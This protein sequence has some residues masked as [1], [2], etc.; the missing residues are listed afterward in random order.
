MC[1]VRSGRGDQM[2]VGRSGPRIVPGTCQLVDAVGD[3]RFS[4][5]DF[6]LSHASWRPPAGTRT[7]FPHLPHRIQQA[8]RGVPTVVRDQLHA[9]NTL[10]PESTRRSS[11]M[12][13]RQSRR[14]LIH[15]AGLVSAAMGETYR[16]CWLELPLFWSWLKVQPWSSYRQWPYMR[17][18]RQSVS[19]FSW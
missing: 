6:R 7:L 12:G 5:F 2:A 8:R 3:F 10:A 4:T 17:T 16:S 15:W 14:C 11:A 18:L 13:P 9:S 1:Q 19:L